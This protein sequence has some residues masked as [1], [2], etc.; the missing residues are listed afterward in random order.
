M[1]RLGSPS[2]TRRSARYPVADPAELVAA[3]HEL[4]AVDGRPPQHVERCDSR[5]AHVH[6]EL[7][8]VPTVR[9]AD[10]AVVVAE[11]Q[12][13]ARRVRLGQRVEHA[14]E[15]LAHRCRETEPATHL[16][17]QRGREVTTRR[18]ERTGPDHGLDALVVHLVG[19]VDHVDARVD[20][21]QDRFLVHDVTAHASVAR[22]RRTHD[23]VELLTRHL[24][25]CLRRPHPVTA[26]HEQLH[27][28][29]AALDL[30]A[31]RGAELVGT[32]AAPGRAPFAQIPVP[33]VPVVRV[34]GRAELVPARHEAR[35][36]NQPV[37]DR[38]LHRRVDV[39]GTPGADGAGEAAL[40][41]GAEVV[42]GD[43]HLVRGCVLEPVRRGR[44]AQL[45]VRRVVVA[46]DHPRHHRAPAEVDDAVG[47]G[48]VGRRR[49]AHARDPVALDHHHPVGLGRCVAVEQVGI[50]QHQSGH[51]I[52]PTLAPPSRDET[53]ATR[54]VQVQARAS[55]R[56][57]C[58]TVSSNRS[59][60][61]AQTN[62]S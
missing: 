42:G 56:R 38:A 51:A 52:P 25:A 58:V 8:R 35:S 34:S 29:D 16:L 44:G 18:H 11:H 13:H 61:S 19:V 22:V 50:R 57:T 17:E 48:H 20:R 49:V 43:E 33:G 45:A 4:G 24:H 21:G 10:G 9:K 54:S 36:G 3:A 55:S 46:G 47:R 2:T 28:L 53:T 5:V 31:H 23:R 30:V 26:G 14:V 39:V 41:R 60:R 12:L 7:V 37:V 62:Q 40:E 59:G 6:L 1:S 32:V 27:H 15:V